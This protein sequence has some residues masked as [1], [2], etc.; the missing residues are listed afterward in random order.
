MFLREAQESPIERYVV[1]YRITRRTFTPDLALFGKN[2]EK[3]KFF[4]SHVNNL[5]WIQ[6]Y[7]VV[8]PSY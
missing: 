4:D 8:L 5:P 2:M 6:R 7:N 3:H 1:S